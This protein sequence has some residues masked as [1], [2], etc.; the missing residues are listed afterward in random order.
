MQAERK[1][2][3]TA[4]TDAHS[5]LCLRPAGPLDPVTGHYLLGYGYCGGDSVNRND[6]S[7][8]LFDYLLRR[9]ASLFGSRSLK[10]GLT[11]SFFHEGA[12]AEKTHNIHEC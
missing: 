4:S 11:P 7:G 8:H 3:G 2:L 1:F 12:A 6:A 10:E 9:Y 5:P